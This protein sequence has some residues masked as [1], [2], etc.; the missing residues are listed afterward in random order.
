M[1]YDIHPLVN[2]SGTALTNA[3]STTNGS[4]TVTIT[5][6]TPHSF[7][8]GDIILLGSFSTITNSN[9]G[10][11]DFNDKKFMVTSVPT[12]DEITITMPS[13]ETGSGA[14]TSGGI[15]YYQYY[16]V[17]PPEQ[18]GAFGWGIA[19]WG[20][21]LLGSLKNTLNGALLDDANGTGGTGTSITL[22]DTTG[23]PSTGTNYIQVGTEEI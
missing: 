8:A 19:L 14:T 20:G 16:H 9:F 4:P 11:S 10:A 5:F 23:F 18:L 22:T 17:G 13:N 7:V 2:P 12:D 15:T 3:F 1:Y 21:N 6:P